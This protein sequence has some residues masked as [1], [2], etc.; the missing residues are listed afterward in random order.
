MPPVAAIASAAVSAVSGLAGAAAAAAPAIGAGVG[1]YSTI[2][3]GRAA[4]AAESK[5]EDYLA[6]QERQAGEYYNLTR[7]EM[8]LQSQASQIKTLAN[9]IQSRRQP[10]EPKIFTLPAAKTYGPVERINR[11]ISDLLKVA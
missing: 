1:V 6:A 4:K 8:E 5:Q 11:G 10:A 9:L 2:E 7:Q 3:A